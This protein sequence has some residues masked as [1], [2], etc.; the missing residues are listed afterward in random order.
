MGGERTQQG[1][2]IH[3]YLTVLIIFSSVI[4]GCAT[5]KTWAERREARRHFLKAQELLAQG[6]YQG[7]LNE[8]KRVLTMPGSPQGDRALFNIAVIYAHHR[9]PKKNYEK[10][11]EYFKRL[12]TDYPES[13]RAEE[14]RIW[15]STLQE[16]LCYDRKISEFDCRIKELKLEILSKEKTIKE[17]VE[18]LEQSK[19]I[20][21]Q[22]E[23]KKKKLK[24]FKK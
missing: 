3:L 6:D 8:N 21:I 22:L 17:L 19:Q 5:L 16:I 12:L 4:W 9:N 2:Y 18:C 24:S 15:M 11:M 20:D 10:S 23:Q 14:S 1:K 7:S 13:S